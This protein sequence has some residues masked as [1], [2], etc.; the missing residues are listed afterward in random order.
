[1]RKNLF[2]LIAIVLGATFIIGGYGCT[3]PTNTPQPQQPVKPL[4]LT[5]FTLVFSDEFNYTGVPDSTKWD[6]EIGFIRNN[7]PQWY[8]KQNAQVGNGVLTI[9]TKKEVKQNDFYNAASSN[10]RY[11]TKTA[12]Y[13]SSSVI[14]K[15]KFDFKY[16]K[17]Q[18]RLKINTAQ[19]QWPA[20]WML[21]SNRGPVAWPAC[22]EVDVMEYY[23]GLMHAN[24]AWEG[25][26]GS[27]WNAK[28]YPITK[29]GNAAYWNDFHIWTIDWDKDYIR[30][31][32]DNNLMNETQITN[33]KNAIRGNN[34]FQEKFYMVMNAALGQDKETI[35]DSTL[36][37]QYQIDYV[38]VYQK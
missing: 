3:P 18:A 29:Y 9:T 20:F 27:S 24:L 32:M 37:S 17:V 13:T 21:G 30:I 7:E 4:P 22:G 26:N 1:M 28:N 14:S 6:Y 33:I 19:G 25:S 10:W 34:P 11:N 5:G 31:F 2:S 23:R 8:Q 15:G 35:P 12:Q 38:R 16:G 36:P